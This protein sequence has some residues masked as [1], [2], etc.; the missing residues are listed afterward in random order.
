LLNEFA[1][2]LRPG[3]HPKPKRIRRSRLLVPAGQPRYVEKARNIETD[4]VTLDLQDG[5]PDTDSAKREA[6]ERAA[7]VIKEGGFKCREIT[8]R[9]N[10]VGTRWILEDI[11]AVVP[12][13]ADSIS[14][15]HTESVR[16]IIFAEGL[17]HTFAEGRDVDVMLQVE[18]PRTMWE[19]QD[20][21]RLS[22]NISAISL[23]PSDF[24]LAMGSRWFTHG[25][26]PPGQF[27]YT[28][29]TMLHAAR[30]MGWNCSTA[31]GGRGPEDFE[32]ARAELIMGRDHGF[33]GAATSFPGMI[34][35]INEVFGASESD[36][37]WAEEIIEA[38]E[39]STKEGGTVAKSKSGMVMVPGYYECAL[40]I[41]ALH[42]RLTAE[43][44]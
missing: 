43:T 8:V 31:A 26:R 36:L 16:D 1:R 32:R 40:R 42:E 14:L 3:E 30:A 4:I 34:P 29:Q 25:Q 41:K 21:A 10:D 2:T 13:G 6:R 39:T 37:A 9:V 23:G 11:E 24:G 18:S 7:A 38:F 12:A 28:R 20:V 44:A 33:D 5:V 27:D 22:T 17:I 15:A 35:L 19:L